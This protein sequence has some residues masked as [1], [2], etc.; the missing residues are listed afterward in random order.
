MDDDVCLVVVVV[1]VVGSQGDPTEAAGLVVYKNGNRFCY[2]VLFFP[3]ARMHTPFI[4]PFS[5][6]KLV[7]ISFS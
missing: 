6:S 7:T 1:V 3:S 4:R 5:L 2:S